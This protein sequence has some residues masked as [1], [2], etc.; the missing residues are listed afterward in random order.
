MITIRADTR[1]HNKRV[2]AKLKL[3][4]N[5]AADKAY[6]QKVFYMFKEL[7]NVSYQFSGDFVSNWRIITQAGEITPYKMWPGKLDFSSQH[8]HMEP[9]QAGDPEAIN[10]AFTRAKFTKFG[11]RDRVYFVNATPLE[12]TG[13]TV[14]GPDGET[15]DLRPVNVIDDGVRIQSYLKAR[16]G[17]K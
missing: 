4:L 16:F 5:E 14:T 2:F 11:A 3:K 13:T 17:S 12:F 9:H 1:A 7:L 6:R 10:F 15:R 8:G